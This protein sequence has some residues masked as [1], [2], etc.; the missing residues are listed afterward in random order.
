MT[1]SLSQSPGKVMRL[2]LS[3]P[4][5]YVLFIAADGSNVSSLLSGI[6][7]SVPP[8]DEP[9]ELTPALP[10]DLARQV[11][12]E[13]FDASA[14]R[15]SVLQSGQETWLEDQPARIALA[16]PST[17]DLAGDRAHLLELHLTPAGDALYER[18]IREY[19]GPMRARAENA[20]AK[21][22]AFLER[23]PDYVERNREHLRAMTRWME[24]GGPEPEAPRFD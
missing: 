11:T 2:K 18:A 1:T 16:N 3:E 4:H 9:I 21:W 8:G 17:W 15:V 20:R 23:H 12:L 10:G 6:L 7:E 14:L 5:Y 19:G 24:H 13:L 22:R